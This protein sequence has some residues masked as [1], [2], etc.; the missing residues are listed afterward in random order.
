ME[1]IS[2]ITGNHRPTEYTGLGNLG[3]LWIVG[4]II[5]VGWILMF[6]IG[7]QIGKNIRNGDMPIVN[8]VKN[9]SKSTSNAPK[10]KD[11]SHYMKGKK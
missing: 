1:L 7:T 6:W 11:P 3:F 10:L 5:L 8:I 4:G 2:S 9:L